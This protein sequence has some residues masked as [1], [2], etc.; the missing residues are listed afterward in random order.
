MAIFM[1]QSGWHSECL[2]AAMGMTVRKCE[3][4]ESMSRILNNPLAWVPGIRRTR[5]RLWIVFVSCVIALLIGHALWPSSGV[6]PDAIGSRP[7]H[8]TLLLLLVAMVCEL[9]DSSLGMGYGTTLTPILLIAGFKPLDLVPCV[10]LSEFLTGMAAGLMHHRDGN[11]DF[12]RDKSARHSV[13]LLSLLSA[14]GAITAVSIAIHINTQWLTI[15]IALMVIGIGV[16]IIGTANRTLKFRR[17]HLVVVGTV[18]AF[19]KGLSGGGYGPLVT[20][21]QVVSGLEA[22]QAVAIT[23]LAES[24]TSLI[25]LIAY[26]LYRGSLD[27]SLA[28]PLTIGAMMSVPIATLVVRRVPQRVMRMSVGIASCVLGFLAILGLAKF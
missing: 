25:G 20:A 11:V 27:F 10:L 12:L 2:I 5:V 4:G 17:G 8:A 19:N 21:G 15:C 9:M 18:A 16:V 14:A 7:F 3:R 28:I 13:V 23:S 26:I 1:P 24:F 6:L 22:K